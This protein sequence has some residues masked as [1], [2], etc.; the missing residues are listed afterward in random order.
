MNC[1]FNMNIIKIILV[2]GFMSLP[3][4]V[5]IINCNYYISIL[6][7]LTLPMGVMFLID[8]IRDL[9]DTTPFKKHIENIFSLDNFTEDEVEFKWNINY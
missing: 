7:I 9:G 1:N 2:I 5:S 3:I 8:I 4:I 6:S